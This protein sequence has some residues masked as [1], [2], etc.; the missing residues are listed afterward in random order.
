ML[1]SR[2]EFI[3]DVLVL[4]KQGDR[5]MIMRPK[6]KGASAF[7]KH[8]PPKAQ[9]DNAS[10]LAQ[11]IRRYR[12]LEPFD[13]PIE[14]ELSFVSAWR[15]AE[16]GRVKK[17]GRYRRKDTHPDNDNL[18]KQV[19]DVLE[20]EGFLASDARVS[21]L[22]LKKRWGP[23]HLLRVRIEKLELLAE[24]FSVTASDVGVAHDDV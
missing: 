15:S 4:P 21:D 9:A 18:S 13:G 19:L 11:A 24:P 7:I 22:I 6:A 2:L 17:S 12:P 20:S 16:S 8:Y 23:R 3:V 10:Q 1:Q 5:S 14:V